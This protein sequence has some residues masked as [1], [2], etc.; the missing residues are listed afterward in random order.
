MSAA[1]FNKKCQ[2]IFVIV[3]FELTEGKTAKWPHF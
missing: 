1:P 2:T 3:D